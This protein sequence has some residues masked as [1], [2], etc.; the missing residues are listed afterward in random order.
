MILTLTRTAYSEEATAGFLLLNDEM[1]YSIEQPWDQN[2]PDHSCVPEGTYDL[3]PYLSPTHGPTWY[4]SNAALGVGA[5]GAVRSYCELH[6][7]NWATQLEGCIA[8]GHEDLPMVD[9][10]TGKL[11]PAVENSRDAVQTLI[12]A[13]G[14]MTS[15]HTLTIVRGATS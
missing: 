6:S 3:I 7:A 13:L 1:L 14:S 15:G 9:P 8:F 2:A 5:A 11:S 4:L 10:S 12:A